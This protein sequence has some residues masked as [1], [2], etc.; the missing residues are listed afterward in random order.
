MSVDSIDLGKLKELLGL[1][2]R[3]PGN[4]SVSYVSF[5]SLVRIYH[6]GYL[7]SVAGIISYL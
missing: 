3:V 6:L 7:A 1:G 4:S 5:A 2:S